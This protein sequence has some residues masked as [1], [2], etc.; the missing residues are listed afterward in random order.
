M[1]SAFDDIFA[2]TATPTLFSAFAAPIAVTVKNADGSSTTHDVDAQIGRETIRRVR[3]N[4]GWKV[5]RT[6]DVLISAVDLATDIFAL[7]ASELRTML[8]VNVEGVK[9]VVTGYD[10][11]P[12]HMVRLTL[13]R[14]DPAEISRPNLR[15]R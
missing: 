12:G 14:S 11:A 6:R 1:P 10:R 15:G 9:Y 4:D 3:I 2:T 8:R 5:L 7:P 13:E